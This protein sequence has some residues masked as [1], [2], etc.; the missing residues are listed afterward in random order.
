MEH[1]WQTILT[2]LLSDSMLITLL[3]VP[4]LLILERL[5]PARPAP[6]RHYLLG[7]GVWLA[8]LALL[9]LVAPLI[10]LAVAK[11]VQLAGLGLLDL[12]V[13]GLEGLGGSLLALAVAT[14][15]L[16]FFLYWY[17]RLLHANPVLWQVHLLH[18]SDEHTNVMTAQRT[19]VL[20]TLLLPVFVTLPMAVLFQ[21]PAVTIAVL[22]VLPQAYQIL[23]HANI[24]LGFGPLW[25]LLYSPDTHRIHHSIEPRH[26]DR[27]FANWFPVWDILFGTSYRPAPD[28]FPPTG[29]TGVEVRSVGAAILLPFAGWWRLARNATATR[30]R[31]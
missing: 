14:F 20:E 8:N 29:V 1:V 6:A 19:H 30:Q 25:W 18:H 28:E 16:D 7:F 31:P 3:F 24:R 11:G 5:R 27:N 17:H 4:P 13:L 22:A 23:V 9:T 12:S 21:L 2:M 10:N 26:F 15:V